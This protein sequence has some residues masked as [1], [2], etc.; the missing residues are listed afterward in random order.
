VKITRCFRLS[1]A[2]DTLKDFEN[3]TRNLKVSKIIL[4]IRG[5]NAQL[6]INFKGLWLD[7]ECGFQE[8]LF[9]NLGN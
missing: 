1:I 3:K 5:L 7:L 2:K 4:Y 6:T 9:E 8:K